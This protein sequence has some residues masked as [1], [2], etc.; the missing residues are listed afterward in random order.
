MENCNDSSE[1]ILYIATQS[2]LPV[3]FLSFRDENLNDT[4]FAFVKE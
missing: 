3:S 4:I 2:S 1:F